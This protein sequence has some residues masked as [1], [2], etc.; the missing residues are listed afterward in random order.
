[1]LQMINLKGNFIFG[2][3]EF[4]L[5]CDIV[6]YIGPEIKRCGSWSALP[7]VTQAVL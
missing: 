6:Y 5:E 3:R 1:M 4:A 7:W 2:Q